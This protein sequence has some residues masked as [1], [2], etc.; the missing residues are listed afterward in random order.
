MPLLVRCVFRPFSRGGNFGLH[1]AWSVYSS[2]YGTSLDKGPWLDWAD[3]AGLTADHSCDLDPGK[4]QV[5]QFCYD[6]VCMTHATGRPGDNA[7]PNEM[8]KTIKKKKEILLT[9]QQIHGRRD[10]E[11]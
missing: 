2:F 10:N 7:P 1:S 11:E 3:E 4:K 6:M 9:A 5:N 8:K